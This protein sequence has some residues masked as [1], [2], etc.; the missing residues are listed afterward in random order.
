[1]SLKIQLNKIKTHYSLELIIIP[2]AIIVSGFKLYGYS[3]TFLFF[4]PYFILNIKSYFLILRESKKQT[5]L[6][7]IFI[8]YMILMSVLGSI[9]IN[10]LRIIVYWI[11]FF[12]V[13]A[14]CYLHNKNLLNKS[15]FYKEN[16]NQIIYVSGFIYF[17]IYL[18]MNILSINYLQ[19]LNYLLRNKN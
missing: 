1:M 9:F 4:L 17:F 15:S 6:V 14:F 5:K 19:S 3:L 8:S 16:F 10:D 2:L 7:L 11:L 13:L 12:I 18:A